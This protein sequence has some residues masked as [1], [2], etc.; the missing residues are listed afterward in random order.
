MSNRVQQSLAFVLHRRDYGETSRILS[1]FTQEYG[2]ID[3]L[4]KGCKSLGKKSRIMELFRL[5]DISWSGRADLKVMHRV[6]ELRTFLLINEANRLYCGFYLNELLYS[7][8]RIGVS[9]P[10]LFKLYTDVL[11]Q[12]SI[13]TKRDIQFLLR[14]FELQLLQVM[15]YGISLD[16]E[17]DG[18]TSIDCTI[19]YGFEP[20]Q[21][22][23]Q[24]S[25]RHQIIVRGDTLL[26]LSKDRFTEQRQCQEAKKLTRFL[27]D[28]YLPSSSIQ[29]RK[30]FT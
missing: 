28:Y 29:S 4:C 15:G 9:E 12:L 20:E 22:F 25:V 11:T 8:I 7:A 23:F 21:G 1:C 3:I 17:Q 2:R 10:K 6:D 5:Y 24:T 30:L 19:D 13:V 18:K 27:I 16:V 26:A 14:Q